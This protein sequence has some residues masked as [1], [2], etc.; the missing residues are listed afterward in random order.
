M[1]NFIF[2][3]HTKT[4]ITAALLL[5]MIIGN[6]MIA[7][8]TIMKHMFANAAKYHKATIQKA[9]IATGNTPNSIINYHWQ[10]FMNFAI[11]TPVR[12]GKQRM[13]QVRTVIVPAS[14]ELILNSVMQVVVS[15]CLISTVGHR[16]NKN[17]YIFV[18][19]R[20][21]GNKEIPCQA[22]DCE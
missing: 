3:M 22:R 16:H 20:R 14:T 21:G 15:A 4:H 10:M 2:I 9:M 13:A 5:S 6:M 17:Q 19:R 1:Y 18:R 11:I 7:S 12:R 8:K